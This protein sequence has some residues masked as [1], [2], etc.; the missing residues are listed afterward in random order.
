MWNTQLNGEP[1]LPVQH[2]G[3]CLCVR[4]WRRRSSHKHSTQPHSWI[5]SAICT[6]SIS[7]MCS[8]YISHTYTITSASHNRVHARICVT[9]SSVQCVGVPYAAAAAVV[10]AFVRFKCARVHHPAPHSCV[11]GRNFRQIRLPQSRVFPQT[12]RGH[13]SVVFIQPLMFIVSL[14]CARPT[15]HTNRLYIATTWIALRV[16]ANQPHSVRL[17]LRLQ[18]RCGF[19]LYGYSA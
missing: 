14:S 12:N 18:F 11:P 10:V 2:H 9:S 19:L 15:C 7:C 16:R 4:E 8:C 6:I 17:L 3:Q 13:T 1:I 5:H